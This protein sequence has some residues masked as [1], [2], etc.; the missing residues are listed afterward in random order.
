MGVT[1]TLRPAF[2][3]YT[4]SDSDSEA[5]DDFVFRNARGRLVYIRRSLLRL[6]DQWGTVDRWAARFGQQ[7]PSMKTESAQR[8]ASWFASMRSQAQMGWHI[9]QHLARVMDGEMPSES[10]WRNIWVEAYQLLVSVHAG[11]LGLELR[12]EMAER[13]Y[14]SDYCEG[15]ILP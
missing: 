4:S 13:W 7:W 2:T 6:E 10:E 11:V 3:S 9:I 1:P 12:L 8:I 14:G 5:A 15:Q